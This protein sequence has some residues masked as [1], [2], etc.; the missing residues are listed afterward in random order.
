MRVMLDT[1]VLFSLL[2]FPNINYAPALSVAGL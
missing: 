2:L 1:N